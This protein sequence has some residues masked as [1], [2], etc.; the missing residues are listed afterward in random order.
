MVRISIFQVTL[1][2]ALA[3]STGCGSSEPLRV[4]KIQLGRSLNPDR[5]VADHTALFRPGDTVYVTVLTADRGAG[6]IGVR[7]TYGGRIVDQP[8][9]D[10]SY[11]T[12]AATEFHL[13]S[14]GPFPEGDYEVEIFVN[15]EPV[16]K[17]AFRVDS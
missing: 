14:P 10:V 6:T 4:S 5:T 1:V 8:K 2:L 11:R 3:C 12:P 16:G 13:Q 15:D 17:R 7:W 9:K